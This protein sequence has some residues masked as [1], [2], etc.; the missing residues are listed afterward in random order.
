MAVSGH[1]VAG[2]GGP[3]PTDWDVVVAGAGP[4]GAVTALHLARRGFRVALRDR[5]AFPREK[6]CG[7]GLIADSLKVLRRAGLFERA[8]AEG[9]PVSSALAYSPYGTVVEVP[10]EAL[11]LERRKLDALLLEAAVGEGADFAVGRVRALEPS[12]GFVQVE[13]EGAEEPLRASYAVLATGADLHLLRPIQGQLPAPSA[14]ALRAYVRSRASLDRMVFAFLRDL[15]PGYG[16]I[17]PMGEGRFNVGVG[18]SFEQGARLKTL[19]RRFLETFPPARDLLR[20]GELLGEPRGATLR[21]GF[22]GA[23]PRPHLRILVAGEALGTTYP[24]SG[25]GIGKAMESGEAAAEA[26]EMALSGG[27]TD[28]LE[29]YPRILESRLKPRYFGYEMAE[30][31]VSRPWLCEAIFRRARKS[32]WMQETLA[33][34]AAETVDPREVFSWKGFFKSL[35]WR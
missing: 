9:F 35:P 16:W 21:T 19:F 14:V 2:G 26:L 7:D 32:R 27:G 17:F 33:G 3:T 1:S 12:G 22:R 15:L 11:V 18:L 4:A 28:S 34:L 6:V 13:V 29:V 10:G 31:W 8:A 30:R 23:S 5:F 20:Q 24:F 25:E